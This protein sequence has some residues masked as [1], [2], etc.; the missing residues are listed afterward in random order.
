MHSIPQSIIK[1]KVDLTTAHVKSGN[2]R[3]DREYYR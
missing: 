2:V 1:H 3:L